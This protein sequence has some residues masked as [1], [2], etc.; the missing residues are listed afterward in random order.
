MSEKVWADIPVRLQFSLS[1]GFSKWLIPAIGIW[2]L[3]CS[4]FFFEVTF[5]CP[6][7]LA[8]YEFGNRK[9]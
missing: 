6:A 3:G 5:I 2:M 9:R 4:F 8:S 1:A 7:V